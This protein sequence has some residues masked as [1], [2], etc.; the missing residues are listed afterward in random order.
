[1]DKL[2]G[3]VYARG[4]LILKQMAFVRKSATIDTAEGETYGGWI[5]GG[6]IKRS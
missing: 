6:V 3:Y 4:V 1:M 5:Q 2:S